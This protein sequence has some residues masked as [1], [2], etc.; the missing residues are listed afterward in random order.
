M[1][2]EQLVIDGIDI[3]STLFPNMSFKYGF[4]NVVNQHIIDV[5]PENEYQTEKFLEAESQFIW[6]FIGIFPNEGVLFTCNNPNI[7]LP[8]IIYEKIKC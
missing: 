4:D 6:D 3:L 1:K 2:P 7:K 5:Q 8:D